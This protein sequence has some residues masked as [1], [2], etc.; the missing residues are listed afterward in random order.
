MDATTGFFAFDASTAHQIA[1]LAVPDPPGLSIRSTMAL[2]V[3]SSA[4]FLRASTRVS[5]PHVDPPP[6][7]LAW[8]FPGM[9]GPVALTMAIF[10]RLEVFFGGGAST[11]MSMLKT[12]KGLLGS[13][14]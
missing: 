3:S 6:K 4:A 14:W 1:S 8:L 13:I 2:T 7:G 9:M 11:C 5:D 10:A 12:A